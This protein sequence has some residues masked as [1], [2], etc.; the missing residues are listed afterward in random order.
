MI[1]S[2]FGTRLGHRISRVF[3]ALFAQVNPEASHVEDAHA[4]A[5][6]MMSP[7]PGMILSQT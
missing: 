2:G 4:I 1:L 3:A 5:A 7:C 6:C